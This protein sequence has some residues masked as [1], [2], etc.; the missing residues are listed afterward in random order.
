[1]NKVFYIL[2][3]ALILFSGCIVFQNNDVDTIK[4]GIV[5]PLSGPIAD[6]GKSIVLA[7]RIAAEDVDWKINDE[8]IE[9]IVEDGK[10]N[11]K[12]AT[13]AFNKLINIDKV[14]FVVGGFCSSETLAASEISNLSKT[15]VISPSSS[16][17]KIRSAGKYMFS[18]YNLSDDE[19]KYIANS[20]APIMKPSPEAIRENDLIIIFAVSYQQEIISLLKNMGYSGDVLCLDRCPRVCP[21]DAL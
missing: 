1:M 8:K 9:F 11:P 6:Y 14:D 10:C 7:L 17:P 18:V 19:G 5:A 15:I 2:I 20:H 13:S 21:I 3:L 12:E 16:S 4:I